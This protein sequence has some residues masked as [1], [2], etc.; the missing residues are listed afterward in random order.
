VET[1]GQG[2]NKNQSAFHKKFFQTENKTKEPKKR[3]D[4]YFQ[5]VLF[6]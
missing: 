6:K 3:V 2:E 1:D 5:K 4:G